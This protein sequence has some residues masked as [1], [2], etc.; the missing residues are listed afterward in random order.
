MKQSGYFGGMLYRDSRREFSL[1]TEVDTR[2]RQHPAALIT[3][4]VV[5][6]SDEAELLADTLV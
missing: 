6:M 2:P 1:W 3:V 5:F 4:F